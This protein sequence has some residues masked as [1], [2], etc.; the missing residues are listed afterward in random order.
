MFTKNRT[1]L[2]LGIFVALMPFLGFPYPFEEVLYVL[3]GLAIATLSYLLAHYRRNARRIPQRRNKKEIVES[4]P[5]VVDM[6]DMVDTV[7]TP[8]DTISP[9]IPEETN[10]NQYNAS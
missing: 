5:V 9:D 10:S 3:A 7:D 4:G 6:S 1:I 8:E 2:I